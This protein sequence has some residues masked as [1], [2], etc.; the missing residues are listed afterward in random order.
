MTYINLV[1]IFTYSV[2]DRGVDYMFYGVVNLKCWS[3]N[4]DQYFKECVK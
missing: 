2:I 1:T 4:K 3:I